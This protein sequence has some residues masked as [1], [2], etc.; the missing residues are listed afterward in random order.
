MPWAKRATKTIPSISSPQQT[1][2]INDY[3]LGMNSFLSNDKFPVKSGGSNLWR[4]A[5]NARIVTLGE[6]STRKGVDF[7]SAAAGETQDDEQESTTGGADQDFNQTD[8]LAQVFTTASA[9][10]LSRIDV[11]IKNP[12]GTSGVPIVEIWTDSSG[13]PGTFL[14]RSSVKPSLITD[15]YQ[16]LPVRFPVAPT[17]TTATDYW[18]V[19]YVQATGLGSYNWSST[20]SGTSA[21]S[22]S[23]G[24]S[25]W[26]ATAFDLNFKQFYA[27]T[28]GVKGLHRAY[29]SDG[30]AVTLFAH[31]TSLYS[32]NESTGALTAIKTGLS[33]SATHYRFVTVNDTVYYV[34]GYDGLRKWDFTT[35]SQV[36]ST[37]YS[38]IEEH[39]GLLFVRRTDDPN[40]V[41]YSNFADYETFTSTDFI[42]VPSPKTGDPT[43]ALKSLNGYLLL[44]TR[45]NKFILSGDD[46]ATFNLD[47]AP[48][49]KGTY[50]QE[51]VSHDKNFVY[52]LS[53]DGVY[54]SNG[55]EAQL[56]SESIYQDV[57]TMQN[58]EQT[59]LIANRGRLHLYFQD[60]ATG[61]NNRSWVWNLNY[62]SGGQDCVESLDT[63]TCIQ[64]AFNAYND[65]DQLLVGCS[66]IGRTYWQ[67]ND[68]ND[69][70][71]NGG[72]I[73]FELDTHY[74]VGAS[75]AVLKEY[76]YWQPRFGAQSGNY[77]IDAEYATD[78]R[79]NWQTYQSVQVQGAGATYGSGVEYGDGTVYG[80]T[81]EVQA[82][83]YVPGEYRRTAIRYK[84]YATRQPQSFLGHT[85]ITQTRRIR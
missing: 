72:D 69:Y 81:A 40:R 17:L 28:G 44:F 1:L 39:K 18:I 42:Y 84:H 19:V 58:K 15:T 55:S 38:L 11:R 12:N 80:T 71:N 13:E 83:L 23:D 82:Q 64:R 73:D 52:Y 27:T 61:Y 7:H 29:K 59:C 65:D 9:G 85:L 47:E 14:A 32:V 30:T 53:D 66:I 37:N 33:A 51:T 60:A 3:S 34:N 2:E 76:R 62:G 43:T 78:L 41:D 21:L 22:S 4:L 5:K 48:D 25:T 50:T 54:R 35:E 56:L 79:S 31:G 36:N 75:P 16:Y 67:E 26:S 24:G 70:T 6:Y 57:L 8:R 49:Q 45:N 63:D 10:M 68:S 20:T 74:M 46:N 77:S